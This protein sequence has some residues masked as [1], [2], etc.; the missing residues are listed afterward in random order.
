MRVGGVI[1][2]GA[3][4][5]KFFGNSRAA[6]QA[7]GRDVCLYCTQ[8]GMV[9]SSSQ[10]LYSQGLMAKKGVKI[11]KKPL[12]I[13]GKGLGLSSLFMEMC[14]ELF[15]AHFPLPLVQVSS[16][17]PI[18]AEHFWHS[19]ACTLPGKGFLWLTNKTKLPALVFSK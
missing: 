19:C 3:G 18:F 4:H 17:C 15:C 5:H 6:G 16:H 1:H 14:Q 10:P 8:P 7:G 2:P 13:W 9:P 11:L 12:G